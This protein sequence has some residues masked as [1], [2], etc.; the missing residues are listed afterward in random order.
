MSIWGGRE[1]KNILIE[2]TNLLKDSVAKEVLKFFHKISIFFS[3]AIH[4][5]RGQQ[6]ENS[7]ALT[8]STGILMRVF[9]TLVQISLQSTRMFIW[10]TVVPASYLQSTSSD[11]SIEKKNMW[12][13]LTHLQAAKQ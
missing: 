4:T 2:M 10:I 12:H 9:L 8:K 5:S 13:F 7:V 3:G 6:K 1:K 11:P